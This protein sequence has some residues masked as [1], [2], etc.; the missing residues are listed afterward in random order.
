[1]LTQPGSRGQTG[2]GF[3]S[4]VKCNRG[5][6]RASLPLDAMGRPRDTPIRKLEAAL[7]CRSCR[8]GRYAPPVYMI[9]LT[10]TRQITPYVRV[11]PDEER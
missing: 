2:C 10:E 4:E 3:C 9:K 7:K 11:H 1:L 5:K 6:T 8:K